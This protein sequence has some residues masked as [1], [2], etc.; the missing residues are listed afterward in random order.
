MDPLLHSFANGW[1]ACQTLDEIP[2][3]IAHSTVLGWQ[4][5]CSSY[6]PHWDCGWL[7]IGQKFRLGVASSFLSAAHSRV[8]VA[9]ITGRSKDQCDLATTAI[10]LPRWY[11]SRHGL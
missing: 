8:F 9:A 7:P 11:R 3:T 10:P 1:L 5:V 2:R 6:G 4:A